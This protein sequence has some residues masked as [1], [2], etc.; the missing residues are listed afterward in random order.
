MQKLNLIAKTKPYT[1]NTY[2]SHKDNEYDKNI[3]QS[4]ICNPRM[5]H[6]SEML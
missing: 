5:V 6:R 2:I 3:T 1:L 4:K